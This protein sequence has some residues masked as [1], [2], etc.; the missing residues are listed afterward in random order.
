MAKYLPFLFPVFFFLMW[1]L[2]TF[3]ISLFGWRTLAK[4]F[5]FMDKFSGDRVGMIS[6]KINFTNYNNAIILYYNEE[7]FYL[8][9]IFLFRLF[10]PPVL[11][12]WSEVKDAQEK[13]FLFFKNYDLTIG[14]P[15]LC[16]IKLQGSTFKK[17]ENAYE[18][19]KMLNKK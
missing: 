6:A 17:I 5:K 14:T 7:G 2:M 9:P 12:P 15:K 16:T 11:V 1:I 3:F 18:T 8:K 10:H 13:K 19:Y 4:R